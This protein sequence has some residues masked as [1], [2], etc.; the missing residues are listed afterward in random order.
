MRL[1]ACFFFVVMLTAFTATA[2]VTEPTTPDQILTGLGFTE[3]DKRAVASGEIIAINLPTVRDNQ[4]KGAVAMRVPV[5]LDRAAAF[6]DDGQRLTVDA[7]VLEF[8]ILGSPVDENDW[9]N[10]RLGADDN[11]EVKRILTNRPASILNVSPEEAAALKNELTPI[12]ADQP[13]ATGIVNNVYRRIL[14][15][16]Y[17]SYRDNGLNG[18]APYVRGVNG[19]ASPA[20]EIRADLAV[21]SFSI[22]ERF[23]AFRRAVLNF[24]ESQPPGVTSTFFWIRTTVEGRPHY[25]LA[26]EMTTR[27]PDFLIVYSRDYY[28]THTYNTLQSTFLWLPDDGGLLAVHVNAGTTDEITGFFSGIARQ[29]G[30]DR[31]KSDLVANFTEVRKQLAR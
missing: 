6:Y 16:R 9:Q 8:G 23:P 11:G 1:A 31:M 5:S 3:T 19:R 2:G 20:V 22:L 21:E 24:P 18:V 17:R 4:L 30:K 26:H 10:V 29:V 25:A 27:G 7:T 14:S 28:S 12:I 13:G 15:E